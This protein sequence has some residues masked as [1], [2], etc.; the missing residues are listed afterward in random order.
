MRRGFERGSEKSWRAAAPIFEKTALTAMC[1][2]Q[3]GIYSSTG[4]R[5]EDGVRAAGSSSDIARLTHYERLFYF[6]SPY[7][8]VSHR[9]ASQERHGRPASRR[10]ER[11]RPRLPRPDPRRPSARPPRTPSLSSPTSSRTPLSA[12]VSRY[13]SI[14]LAASATASGSVPSFSSPWRDD[15]LASTSSAAIARRRRRRRRGCHTQRRRRESFSNPRHRK[16]FVRRCVWRLG[17]DTSEAGVWV[18]RAEV[19]TELLH[20][21]ELRP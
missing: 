13:R 5:V 7:S 6:S 18:K 1:Q 20:H 10:S 17:E 9:G 15:A 8:L 21:S 19:E 4:Y 16:H 2:Q 14:S 12:N 3:A 11:R